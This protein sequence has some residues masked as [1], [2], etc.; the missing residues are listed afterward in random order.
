MSFFPII[1]L[2]LIHLENFFLFGLTEFIYAFR[3]GLKVWVFPLVQDTFRPP[4][5]ISAVVSI[6]LII[7]TTVP[8]IPVLM[9]HPEFGMR[10]IHHDL[11]P[12]TYF[13]IPYFRWRKKG[14]ISAFGILANHL[15]SIFFLPLSGDSLVDRN[16]FFF[17]RN[18]F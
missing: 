18:F 2:R 16:V 4:P 13:L 1:F 3:S 6:Y 10:S 7:S 17:R 12:K 5:V 14:A 15:V 9:H 11:C 8:Q